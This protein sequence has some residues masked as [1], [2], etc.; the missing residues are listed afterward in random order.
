MGCD[1][2]DMTATAEKLNTGPGTDFY[3]SGIG[4]P[5]ILLRV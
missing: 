1:A 2:R 5:F 3:P 4:L